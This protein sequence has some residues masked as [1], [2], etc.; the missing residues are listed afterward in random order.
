MSEQL[1]IQGNDVNSIIKSDMSILK[2]SQQLMEDSINII[3]YS[4]L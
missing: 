2:P 4:S 1:Q 3:R